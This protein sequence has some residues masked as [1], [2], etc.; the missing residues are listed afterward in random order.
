MCLLFFFKK[1]DFLE[2]FHG[3]LIVLFSN[4]KGVYCLGK[5]IFKIAFMPV[6]FFH[7]HRDEST[8]QFID[9]WGEQGSIPGV[10]T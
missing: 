7:S 4:Q 6:E 8:K 2:L 5:D 10:N 1:C 3:S 9:G